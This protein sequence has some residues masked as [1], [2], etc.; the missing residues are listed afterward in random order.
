MVGTLADIVSP[1]INMERVE[2]IYHYFKT[3]VT[4]ALLIGMGVVVAA[5]TVELG[6]QLMND[7]LKPTG[8]LIDLSELYD[9][10]GLFLL[11]LIAIELMGSVYIYLKDES[12]HLEIMFLVA[13]TAVTRKIVVLDSGE[14][15]ALYLMGLA[16]LI[17]ALSW[18]YI[19]VVRAHKKEN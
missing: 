7:L 9:T 14:T 13:I 12:L 3:G 19:A 11:V 10:F 1:V 16:L 8:L 5:S 4:I 17:A 6:Y 2:R 18:G 15:N